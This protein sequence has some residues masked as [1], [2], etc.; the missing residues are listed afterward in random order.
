M[1]EGFRVP[2][3]N[4]DAAGIEA[5]EG[6]TITLQLSDDKVVD[7]VIAKVEKDQVIAVPIQQK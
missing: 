5:K 2:I 3:K 4:L 7:V 6:T 1:V